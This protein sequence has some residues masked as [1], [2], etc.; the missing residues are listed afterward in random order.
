MLFLLL[1]LG[2]VKI[3]KQQRCVKKIINKLKVSQKKPLT[4]KIFIRPPVHS[5][6]STIR[7]DYS[8][9]YYKNH[10]SNL[11]QAQVLLIFKLPQVFEGYIPTILPPC[12]DKFCLSLS[13][14][15]GVTRFNGTPVFCFFMSV[16]DPKGTVR[17]FLYK[18]TALYHK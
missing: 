9:N 13:L 3:T 14:L 10:F 2:K 8:R 7:F 6:Q 4:K 18:E 16:C 12:V 17:V 1:N 11:L 5:N 15:T